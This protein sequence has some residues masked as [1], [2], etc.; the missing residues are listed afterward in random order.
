[1]DITW[2]PNTRQVIIN[3]DGSMS[4]WGEGTCN[5]GDP[6]DYPTDGIAGGSS[7]LNVKAKKVHIFDAENVSWEEL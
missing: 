1:M 5:E 7:I 4:Y 6:S 2:N 3:D